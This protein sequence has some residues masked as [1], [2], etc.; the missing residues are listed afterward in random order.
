MQYT[1]LFVPFVPFR[2][3]SFL[4]CYHYCFDA[5]DMSLSSRVSFR[6]VV[7]LPYSP[8]RVCDAALASVAFLS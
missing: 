8:Y 6:I 5:S 3:I 1:Y 2:F 4:L 7:Q